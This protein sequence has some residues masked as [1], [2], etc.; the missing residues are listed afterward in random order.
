[1]RLPEESTLSGEPAKLVLGGS[2]PCRFG[3]AIVFLDPFSDYS[4]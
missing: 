1:M 4:F 3:W 2:V